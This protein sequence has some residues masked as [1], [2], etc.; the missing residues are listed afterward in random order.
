[1]PIYEYYCP[2]CNQRFDALKGMEERTSNPCPQCDTSS[3]LV[4]SVFNWWFSNPFTK[5]GEG[6]KTKYLRNEELDEMNRELKGR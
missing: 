2:K 6:F 1:M 5:D 3:R 4:L